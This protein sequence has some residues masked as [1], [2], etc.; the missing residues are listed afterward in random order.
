MLIII[1]VAVGVYLYATCD[2]KYVCM[3]AVSLALL[4]LVLSSNLVML[5]TPEM[6]IVTSVVALLATLMLMKN[7]ERKQRNSRIGIEP[8]IL[9][10]SENEISSTQNDDDISNI[11]MKA[12]REDRL[13]QR[14]NDFLAILPDD[15]RQ[16]KTVTGVLKDFGVAYYLHNPKNKRSFYVRVDDTVVWG[17][18]LADAIANSSVQK[19]DSIVLQKEKETVVEF[20]RVIDENGNRITSERLSVPKRRGYWSIT[21]V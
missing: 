12:D 5:R 14:S 10:P 3:Y 17:L 21:P 8:T 9:L 19:G 15:N 6:L 2:I 18:G 16:K 4:P 1:A 7:T 11:K 20:A 13:V